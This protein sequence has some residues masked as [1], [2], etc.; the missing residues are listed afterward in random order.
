MGEVAAASQWVLLYSYLLTFQYRPEKYERV[1]DCARKILHA[2]KILNIDVMNALMHYHSKNNQPIM[3]MFL[4]V[5]A[6][7]AFLWGVNLNCLLRSELSD[8]RLT[9]AQNKKQNARMSGRSGASR[10]E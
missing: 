9:S 2:S 4:C 3:L 6:L 8:C 10:G 5:M 1:S 7:H